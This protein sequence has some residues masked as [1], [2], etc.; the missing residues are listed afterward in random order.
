M[1]SPIRE[2]FPPCISMARRWIAA[3]RGSQGQ[4]GGHRA[5]TELRLNQ[6]RCAEI[7]RDG[8]GVIISLTPPAGNVR[9]AID[10]GTKMSE[11]SGTLADDPF[12]GRQPTSHERLSGVPWDVSYHD[13]PA[14]W[15]I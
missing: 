6:L 8:A 13:G 12:R 10:R 3:P 14:P 7:A 9:R 2:R 15:D 4:L 1:T 5:D 11:R